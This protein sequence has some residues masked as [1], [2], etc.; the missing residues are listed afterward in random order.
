MRDD[1]AIINS[2]FEAFIAGVNEHD[3]QAIRALFASLPSDSSSSLSE[4]IDATFSYFPGALTITETANGSRSLSS[5]TR[6]V[7][8]TDIDA[9]FTVES[10]GQVFYAAMKICSEDSTNSEEVGIISI[11][12]IDSQ[13]YHEEVCYRGDGKWTPGINLC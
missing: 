11:Y 4:Q 1:K 3:T 7:R 6:G 8:R 2:Y 9:L 10:D 13:D 12:F 5:V